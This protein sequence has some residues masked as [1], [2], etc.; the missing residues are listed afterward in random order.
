MKVLVI[1]SSHR[2]QSNSA[3]L[4]DK[5]AAGATEAGADVQIED[6]GK[7]VIN[8]CRGCYSCMLPTNKDFCAIK[9]DMQRFYKPVVE[10][11]AI[12]FAGPIY[13]FNICG[14]LKQFID[15]CF[16]AAVILGEDGKSIFAHKKIAAATA[17]EDVDPMKSGCV[18]MIR[19]FQDM[20][21]YTGAAWA[22]AAYGTANAQGEMAA[23]EKA[24]AEA[25]ELGKSLV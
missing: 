11:D 8:N 14:Q 19:M 12:V 21:H 23:N 3:L 16:A 4:A 5:I 18:N 1:K 13:W 15:R 2:K 10:A 25:F 7:L 20:C 22:G 6:I 9:D 24:L 17:Y